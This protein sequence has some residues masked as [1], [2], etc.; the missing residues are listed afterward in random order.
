MFINGTSEVSILVGLFDKLQIFRP[1]GCVFALTV[2]LIFL[3][4]SCH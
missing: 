3:A 1:S 2:T 4:A